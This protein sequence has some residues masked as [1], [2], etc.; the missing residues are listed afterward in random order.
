MLRRKVA[1][2]WLSFCVLTFGRLTFFARGA[3]ATF[4][5]VA[6]IAVTGTAW[7]FATVVLA[8]LWCCRCQ[9]RILLSQRQCALCIGLFVQPSRTLTPTIFATWAALAAAFAARRIAAC[10]WFA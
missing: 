9:L 8:G 4:T 7:T 2:C 10:L 1:L 6:A 5:T 3:V